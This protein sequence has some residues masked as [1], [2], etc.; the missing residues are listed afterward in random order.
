MLTIGLGVNNE[1]TVSK[2]AK[3]IL[4]RMEG[5]RLL[6]FSAAG[7]INKGINKPEKLQTNSDL[8]FN[9]VN[10]YIASLTDDEQKR[11]Y[12]FYHKARNIVSTDM[13]EARV[14]KKIADLINEH[15]EIINMPRI[16]RWVESLPGDPAVYKHIIDIYPEESAL[17]EQ[18]DEEG[19]IIESV[20]R[21]GT[22]IKTLLRNEVRDLIGVTIVSKLIAPVICAYVYKFQPQFQKFIE[23][24]IFEIIQECRF[25]KTEPI[26]PRLYEYINAFIGTQEVRKKLAVVIHSYMSEEEYPDYIVALLF[27]SKLLNASIIPPTRD[28]KT[29]IPN[30]ISST[31]REA[32]EPTKLLGESELR[33]KGD[34]SGSRES[35]DQERSEFD[36]ISVAFTL[37]PGQ[38]TMIEWAAEK[39]IQRELF[40][41]DCPHKRLTRY[42]PELVDK[43]LEHN[44]RSFLNQIC[45]RQ[46]CGIVVNEFIPLSVFDYISNKP[47]SQHMNMLYAISAIWLEQNGYHQIAALQTAVGFKDPVYCSGVDMHCFGEKDLAVLDQIYPSRIDADKKSANTKPINLGVMLIDKIVRDFAVLKWANVNGDTV[48][49]PI[50][51]RQQLVSIIKERL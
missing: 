16:T 20:V 29:F 8:L 5:E 23:L 24:K 7:M 45:Q 38:Q 36:R 49:P 35:M 39:F 13:D 44:R 51:F 14:P 41:P 32:S 17:E 28:K 2:D 10:M 48:V 47:E 22:K 37:S 40:E 42:D 25:F 31:V 46:I 6:E 27:T 15:N 4:V 9:M 26:F 33:N 12:A 30:I 34:E 1:I 18:V 3:T 50:D 19:K 21:P 43:Y 11:L